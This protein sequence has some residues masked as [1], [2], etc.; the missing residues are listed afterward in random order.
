[1]VKED[2][3]SALIEFSIADTGVGIPKNKIEAIYDYFQ[4]SR[5]TESLQFQLEEF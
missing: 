1:M 4:Q 3:E 2:T 5:Q